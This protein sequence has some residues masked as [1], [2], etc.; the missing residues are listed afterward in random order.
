MAQSGNTP[1]NSAQSPFNKKELEHFRELLLER[2]ERILSNVT[3][4]EQEAL[5]A[6][7]QDFSA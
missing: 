5:K 4:M 1:H 7:D 6:A 3:S 2:R